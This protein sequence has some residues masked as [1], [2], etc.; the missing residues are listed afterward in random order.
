M[1]RISHDTYAA[2]I[3][4]VYL[5]LIVNVSLV[6]ACLPFVVALVTTDPAL[7]WPLLA[8][9]APLC[10]PGIAAAFRAFRE[11]DEGGRTPIRA[12]VAGLRDT[13]LRAL[14]LG[15]AVTAVVVIALIDVRAVSNSDV[16]VLLVPMLGVAVVIAVAVGLTALVALAEV[17]TARWAD[18]LR[19]SAYLSLKRWYFT[20]LSLF[21]VGAQAA[22]FTTAPAIALG[23]TASA[24]LYFAWTNAR[25][26]LRPVLDLE[27]APAA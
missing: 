18:V 11:Y 5:F 8:V 26:T 9:T 10:A 7:S 12:F 27:D 24:A 13:G 23:I 14:V 25:F 4:M 22:L 15:F 16:G 19:A 21:A 2:I 17:P 6:V 20:A 1:K 3:G